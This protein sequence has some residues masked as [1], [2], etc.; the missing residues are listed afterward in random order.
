MQR[1]R[2]IEV[3]F[4][5]KDAASAALMLMKAN[6][7]HTAGIIND[8]DKQYVHSKARTF[9]DDATLIDEAFMKSHRLSPKSILALSEPVA[10]RPAFKTLFAVATRAS[11]HTRQRVRPCETN[12]RAR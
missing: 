12:M 5:I 6:C 8:A 11:E 3:I 2:D 9:L 4:P 1:A 10:W 7:L